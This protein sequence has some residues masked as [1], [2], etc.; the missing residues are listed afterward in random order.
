MA[1]P[2]LL[3]PTP[4][5]I[6]ATSHRR[7]C[8]ACL[9]QGVE[10]SYGTIGTPTHAA[11][12]VE[13]FAMKIDQFNVRPVTRWIVTRFQQED[14]RASCSGWGGFDNQHQAVN[15]AQCMAAYSGAEYIGPQMPEPGH[16][17]GSPA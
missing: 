13:R 14:G 16:I 4:G 3:C 17:A 1:L 10:R 7:H 15:V 6:A 9:Q 2:N 12:A 5:S 11:A 8:M